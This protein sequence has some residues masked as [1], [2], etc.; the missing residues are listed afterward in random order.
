MVRV[1]TSCHPYIR[2]CYLGTDTQLADF[3]GVGQR[4]IG[5]AVLNQCRNKVDLVYGAALIGVIEAC[6]AEK[7]EGS[8]GL[9]GRS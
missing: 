5:Y 9:K 3:P 7:C 8:G 1:T 4:I 6:V 2:F